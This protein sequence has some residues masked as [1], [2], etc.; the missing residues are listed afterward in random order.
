M[1]Q[2]FSSQIQ[3]N[4]SLQKNSQHENFTTFMIFS[5]Y[6][7]LGFSSADLIISGFNNSFGVGTVSSGM[8]FSGLIFGLICAI[9][10]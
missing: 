10:F 5:D 8:G 2:F 3:M 9:V 4:L 6:Y 1:T 7:T